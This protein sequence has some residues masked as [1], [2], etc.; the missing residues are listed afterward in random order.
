VAKAHTG[1][2]GDGIEWAG[3][4]NTDLEPEIKDPWGREGDFEG[5]L[6]PRVP[7]LRIRKGRAR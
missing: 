5:S 4:E 2:I 6:C 7:N 3:R 1:D